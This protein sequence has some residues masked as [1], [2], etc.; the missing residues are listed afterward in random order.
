MLRK[1]GVDVV[2]LRLPGMRESRILLPAY[3]WEVRVSLLC[4]NLVVVAVGV[5]GTP[6][7]GCR[8]DAF[9][10]RALVDLLLLKRGK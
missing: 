10:V 3:R 4:T 6:Q 9:I 8:S 2:M 1:R 7:E 5:V